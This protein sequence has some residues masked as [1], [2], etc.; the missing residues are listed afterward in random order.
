MIHKS[1]KRKT[2]I[3]KATLK[4]GTGKVR[5][6]KKLL[7]NYKP[8]LYQLKIME[9]MILAAEEAK[10]LDISVVVRGGGM[11][12]QAEAV[13]LAIGRCLVEHSPKLK[14]VL[15]DYDR[16]LLV[17]DV[18]YKE[19]HKPLMHGTARGKKQKSYR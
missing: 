1:G 6:N 8:K 3:A 18:R 10:D 2:A 9:P 4:S 13:A 17:A 14:G 11:M 16:N 7:E 15:L 5:I 19:T 12:S